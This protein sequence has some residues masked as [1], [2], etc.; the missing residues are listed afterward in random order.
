MTLEDLYQKQT[1]KMCKHFYHHIYPLRRFCN[2]AHV[3]STF[4]LGEQK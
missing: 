3:Y 4:V 1:K 2:L